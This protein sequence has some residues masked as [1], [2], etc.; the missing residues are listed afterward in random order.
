MLW[1][2]LKMEKPYKAYSKKMHNDLVVVKGGRPQIDDSWGPSLRGFL[3]SCWHQDLSK[4]PTATKASLILKREAAKVG[5]GSGME[6]NNF[7]RR[8]TYVNV[9]ALRENKSKSTLAKMKA[10]LAD[11]EGDSAQ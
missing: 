1:E 6:L 4:R 8:S 2:M 5:G 11:D 3:A 10:A 7:R 9:N